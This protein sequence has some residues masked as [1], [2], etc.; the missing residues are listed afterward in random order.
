MKKAQALELFGGTVTATARALGIT[1]SAVSQ[2]EDELPR[3]VEERILA[4]LARK[5]LPRRLL[6]QIGA[7]LPVEAKA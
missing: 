7:T 3:A 1:H 2:W 4:A 5:H 6:K